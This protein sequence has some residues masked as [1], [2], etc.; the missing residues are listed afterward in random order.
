MGGGYD[1]HWCAVPRTFNLKHFISSSLMS[2]A[3]VEFAKQAQGSVQGS[4][5]GQTAEGRACDCVFCIKK[6]GQGA[7][8]SQTG[9]GA[10]SKGGQV[11]TNRRGGQRL[12]RG[13]TTWGVRAI[14]LQCIDVACARVRVI[15]SNDELKRS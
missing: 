3:R 7:M 5:L 9:L 13:P 12:R 8:A 11:L 10:S 2:L 1:V 6:W 15:K 4:K 14:I